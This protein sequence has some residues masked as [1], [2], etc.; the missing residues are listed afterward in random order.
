MVDEEDAIILR[1]HSIHGN[2]W[3]SIA[4]LLPGRTDNS[5]KNH[6]NS[7]LKR[8]G[9][10]LGKMKL[11]P[12]KLVED[13]TADKSKASSEETLSCGDVHS[14]KSLEGKDVSAMDMAGQYEDKALTEN[15]FSTEAKDPPTLFCPVARIGAF[16]IYNPLDGPE[17]V[18]PFRKEASSQGIV[19]LP[20]KPDDQI[21]KLLEKAYGDQLVPHQCGHGCCGTLSGKMPQGSLLGPNFVD[22]VEPPSFPSHDLAVLAADISG[23]AWLKSGLDNSSVQV[24]DYA[25]G[26]LM[27]PRGAHVQMGH[28]DGSTKNGDLRIQEG[29]NN[30]SGRMMTEVLPTPVSRQYF[31]QP[32]NVARMS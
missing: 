28:F 7:T 1:A 10:E 29:K 26:R 30:L 27:M 22:Y 13:V 3:A 15:Q 2:K 16:S 18:F 24:P 19:F 20:S 31:A 32:S 8:R 25:T 23:M 5:I 12:S 14:F 6:W 11:E 21:N 17:P 4:K 9:I